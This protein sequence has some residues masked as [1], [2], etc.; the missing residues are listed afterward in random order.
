MESAKS[1]VPRDS[2]DGVIAPLPGAPSRRAME[3]L[4]IALGAP[5][6]TQLPLNTPTYIRLRETIRGEIAAGIFRPGQH[7]TLA[8]LALRYDTSHSPVREALL[9]LLCQGVVDMPPNKGATVIEVGASYLKHFFAVRGALQSMLATRACQ[10]CDKPRLATLRDRLSALRQVAAGQDAAALHDADAAFHEELNQLGQN[11]HAIDILRP[12]SD[13][14]TAFRRSRR[15]TMPAEPHIWATTAADLV[16]AIE[17][18]DA[19]TAARCVQSHMKHLERALT[20]LLAA[21]RIRDPMDDAEM[22]HESS[23]PQGQVDQYQS[24]NAQ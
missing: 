19:S 15:L 5:M 22:T 24:V 10:L 18:R 20:D 16:R 6:P 13:L 1:L 21:P 12:R 4:A 17:R 8:E 2:P 3:D 23:L 7:L 14:V 11:P 9:Q